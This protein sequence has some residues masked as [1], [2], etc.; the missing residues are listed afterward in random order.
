M[1][2]AIAT[3]AVLTAVV[4]LLGGAPAT[5]AGCV[6]QVAWKGVRY[7]L[8]VTASGFPTGRRLG[9]GTVVSCRTTSPGGY[10]MRAPV[11]IRRALYAVPG[12]RAQVAVAVRSR[13]RASLWV[14]T[15]QATAA[16]R[17][18]LNR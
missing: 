10:S 9:T 6:T 4:A 2:R 12:V 16:E 5:G 17:A 1:R 11:A 13:T 7:K 18:V 8:A 15:T 14:S 3:A